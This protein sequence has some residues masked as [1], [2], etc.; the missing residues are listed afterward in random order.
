MIIHVSVGKT[1]D[2]PT[3]L[4]DKH[5]SE[6]KRLEK[7]FEVAFELFL[8]KPVASLLTPEY[9]DKHSDQAF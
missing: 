1:A 4:P 5:E 6:T 8:L 3:R 9:K 7:E 2:Q